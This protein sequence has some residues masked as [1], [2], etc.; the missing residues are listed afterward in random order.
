M[1]DTLLNKWIRIIL[2][3]L[4]IMIIVVPMV[5]SY[6]TF[7][8]VDSSIILT[9]MERISEGYVPYHD[10]HL[11]YPPLWFYM[12]VFLKRL[13]CVPF[14]C[15]SFYLTIHHVFSIACAACV[16]GLSKQFGAKK[17]VNLFSAWLFLLV[18]QWLSGDCV[19]FEIPSLLFGLLSC[20]LVLELRNKN[21]FH[22]IYI[23]MLSCCSFLCKQFGAGFLLL[24]LYLILC[25]TDHKLKK[26]LYYIVGYIV[27]LLVCYILFG[28]NMY[29]SIL[30]NGYGTTTMELAGWDCAPL[31]K[32]KVIG[33]NIVYFSVKVIP[34]VG[35]SVLFVPLFVLAN[36]YKEYIFCFCAIC[37]F[38]LQ[39]YFVPHALHYYQ[40]MLPWAVLICSLLLCVVA[41]KNRFYKIFVMIIVLITTFLSCYNVHRRKVY[42]MCYW[43]HLEKKEQIMIANKLKKMN[44]SNKTIWVA[45]TELQRYN[46]LCNFFPANIK[47]VGY[48]VGPLEVTKEKAWLQI[49]ASDYVLH[50]AVGNEFDYYYNGEIA[51]YLASYPA[52]TI[53]NK[54]KIL[55]RKLK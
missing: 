19:L 2:S 46:Y 44:L 40:Y 21:D 30:L 52:D 36:K 4:A 29:E 17:E 18:L 7:I 54:G 25:F 38:A 26:I 16:Y 33:R 15:Y 51:D 34:V 23:G 20:L 24:G 47:E 55:L 9:E 43:S 32:L 8:H 28:K 39:F 6:F 50:Y 10:I 22:Y 49:G 27:P 35:C 37:G 53:D 1:M 11:N 45:H 42:R 13:F 3:I 41:D 31:S 14:G 12:M 48:A 5:R